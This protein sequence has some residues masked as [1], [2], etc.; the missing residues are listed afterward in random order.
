MQDSL[1]LECDS[2]SRILPYHAFRNLPHF[3]NSV[4]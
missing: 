3:G 2:P 4:P 1:H